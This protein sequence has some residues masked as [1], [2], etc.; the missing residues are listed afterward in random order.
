MEL[1]REEEKAIKGEYGPGL[2]QAYKILVAIGIAN[3]ATKFIPVKWAHI[4]GVNYNTIGDAGLKFLQSID[5]GT[6]VLRY[7]YIKSHGI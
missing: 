6:K 7:E 5:K 4:S 3:N 2:E 1:T